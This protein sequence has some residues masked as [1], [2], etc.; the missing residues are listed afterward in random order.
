MNFS[1]LV[2]FISCLVWWVKEIRENF[3]YYIPGLL[4]KFYS[5]TAH[6]ILACLQA[7]KKTT[8]RY[9]QLISTTSA[10]HTRSQI[11]IV[12]WIRIRKALLVGWIRIHIW[13]E[14][15]G[16]QKWPKKKVE[17]F[18]VL[19]CSC[20]L[21]SSECFSWSLDVLYEGLGKN[22]LRFLVKKL[23]SPVKCYIFGY[24][25]PGSGSAWT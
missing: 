5:L 19:K 4:F 15:P 6:K 18:H 22:K 2:A 9:L 24:Q 7:R 14:N 21:F 3:F 10:C 12:L 17:K 25:N 16:W 23:L 11:L 1:I 13:N 8:V 20:S